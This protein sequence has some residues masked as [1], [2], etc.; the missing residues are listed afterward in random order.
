MKKWKVRELRWIK[1]SVDITGLVTLEWSEN[2]YLESGYQ[3]F[4]L[5]QVRHQYKVGQKWVG[6]VHVPSSLY[7][8]TLICH[9]V[10]GE[11]FPW[12]HLLLLAITI[13][14]IPLLHKSQSLEGREVIKT[15]NL[16]F[17]FQRYLNSLCI[18]SH[19]FPC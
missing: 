18:S 17:Q 1:E 2:R 8:E 6:S 16:G 5:Q 11:E 12:C 10:S 14:M 13:F 19:M 15:S 4:T 3:G 9:L 7:V